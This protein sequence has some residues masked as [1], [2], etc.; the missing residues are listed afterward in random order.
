MHCPLWVYA[1]VEMSLSTGKLQ[2]FS[3]LC[4]QWVYASIE[5]SL[6]TCKLQLSPT[7]RPC[8]LTPRLRWAYLL[9]S[10]KIMH[11]LSTN[12]TLIN[13]HKSP[14]MI[15]ISIP[16]LG[17]PLLR[18]LYTNLTRLKLHVWGVAS[19]V[20]VPSWAIEIESLRWN[21]TKVMIVWD[22]TFEVHVPSWV[23]R[24]VA[25]RRKIEAPLSC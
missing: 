17:G 13:D 25:S 22:I 18:T 4:P 1:S 2:P 7:R 24:G 23:D 5:M 6:S 3:T 11:N 20:H 21:I 16:V 10:F 15:W 9:E 8:G 19:E 12:H 14:R